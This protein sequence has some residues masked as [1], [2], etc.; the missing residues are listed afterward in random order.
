MRTKSGIRLKKNACPQSTTSNSGESAVTDDLFIVSSEG[1]YIPTNTFLM[2]SVSPILKKIL[3]DYQYQ[4]YEEKTKLYLP[5]FDSETLNTF[6]ELINIGDVCLEGRNM[7]AIKSLLVS[8]CIN[9]DLFTIDPIDDVSE[10]ISRYTPNVSGSDSDQEASSE[11]ENEDNESN[12]YS[13][14]K[15][16]ECPFQNCKATLKTSRFF[17]KHVT[18]KH[19][20]SDLKKIIPKRQNGVRKCPIEDCKFE[21]IS[22]NQRNILNHISIIHDVVKSKFSRMFPDHRF[23]NN[24]E[25][26]YA[27]KASNKKQ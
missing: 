15:N 4:T 27:K 20:S 5:D 2:G 19:F 8:L 18:N 3:C 24:R 10:Y 23:A 9:Q 6:L 7:N 1:I 21:S 17:W 11:E 22:Y 12:D 25:H 26:S 16:V 13:E 14:K